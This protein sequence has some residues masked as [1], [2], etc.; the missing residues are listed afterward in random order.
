MIKLIV[1]VIVFLF[2]LTLSLAITTLAYSGVS[3]GCQASSHQHFDSEYFLASSR[4]VRS[5]QSSEIVILFTITHVAIRYWP[6]NWTDTRSPLWPLFCSLHLKMSKC[7]LLL[8]SSPTGNLALAWL[9]CHNR[10]RSPSLEGE[11]I[12]ETNGIQLFEGFF[13]IFF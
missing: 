13:S 2:L 12:D 6:L 10:G 4:G 8:R 1:T 5:F 11:S 7:V 3:S 9:F